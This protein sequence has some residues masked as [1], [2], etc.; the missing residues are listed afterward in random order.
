VGV[1][2]GAAMWH[3]DS[4]D[5]AREN[6]S[7][8][9]VQYR[10]SWTPCSMP[11][12]ASQTKPPRF[13]IDLS[14]STPLRPRP[15]QLAEGLPQGRR[16][17]ER[18]SCVRRSHSPP[19]SL[20]PPAAPAA[21]PLLL[22]EGRRCRA[23]G[24]AWGASGGAPVLLPESPPTQP[25]P[26]PGSAPARQRRHLQHQQQRRCSNG[27]G[28]SGGDG[29]P[30]TTWPPHCRLSALPRITCL[31]APLPPVP[32]L[33]PLPPH[34]PAPPPA[35][36]ATPLSHPCPPALRQVPPAR[37]LRCRSRSS[38]P[39]V[40][41]SRWWWAEAGSPSRPPHHSPSHR[42]APPT[43]P[44]ACWPLAPGG[45][46]GRVQSWFG[47][48]ESWAAGPDAAGLGLGQLGQTVLILDPARMPGGY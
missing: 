18:T 7:S 32:P 35:R 28:S 43:S 26:P 21:A 23:G 20:R 4:A 22:L 39:A 27:G 38:V 13:A 48:M 47:R 14:G 42:F 37:S 12:V 5:S 36:P 40:P 2:R 41:M 29:Q 16:R 8:I 10:S 25:A 45:R 24:A 44:C 1:P 6:P 34:P 31:P 9:Q 3:A 17:V 19:W 11:L 33:P 15:S 46:A 30:H